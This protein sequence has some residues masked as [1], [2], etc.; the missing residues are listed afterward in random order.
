MPRLDAASIKAACEAEL[1]RLRTDYIDLFYLHWPDRYVPAFGTHR[2]RLDL[3]APQ[4]RALPH[5]T[6]CYG[7]RKCRATPS[8]LGRALLAAATPAAVAYPHRKRQRPM[9]IGP[10]HA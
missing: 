9:T 6:Y 4:L 7:H 1:R 2:Y 8:P 3:G 10:M 5:I